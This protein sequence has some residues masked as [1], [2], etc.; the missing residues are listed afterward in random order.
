[1]GCEDE[2]QFEIDRDLIREHLEANN[3]E[4][5]PTQ[6]GLYYNII[7]QGGQVRPNITNIVEVRYRGELL[8]GTIFD[9]TEGSA[10]LRSPLAGLIQGWQLGLPLI[11]RGGHIELYIPSALGYGNR[12]VGDI[13]ANSVLYFDIR[14]TDFE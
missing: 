10:V 7:D 6:S 2:T 4:A 8:D 11:G 5:T 14:L 13:P 1:M 12:A 9:Q 3:L